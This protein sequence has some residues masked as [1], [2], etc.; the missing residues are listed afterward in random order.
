MGIHMLETTNEMLD[1][2]QPPHELQNNDNTLLVFPE[3][4]EECESYLCR[5]LFS[6]QQSERLHVVVATDKDIYGVQSWC[7]KTFLNL[8]RRVDIASTNT[9]SMQQDHFTD[10]EVN[11]V[12]ESDITE[13]GLTVSGLLSQTGEHI[14]TVLC[15]QPLTSFLTINGTEMTFKFLHILTGRIKQQDNV[16]AHYHINPEGINNND[17]QTIF[18]IFD[19]AVTYDGEKWQ[20]V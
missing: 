4:Q 14:P 18:T 2:P 11:I 10:G 20:V 5:D 13:F 1:L 16:Q 19:N 3:S 17:L 7:E 8:P 9:Q 6:N 12:H 15:F